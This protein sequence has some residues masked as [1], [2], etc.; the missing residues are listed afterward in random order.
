MCYKKSKGLDA[1]ESVEV[2]I[3]LKVFPGYPFFSKHS[4]IFNTFFGIIMVI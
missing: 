4:G 2:L 1:N 3:A